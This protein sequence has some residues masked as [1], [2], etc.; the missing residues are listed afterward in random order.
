MRPSFLPVSI[1]VR[2]CRV[3][4]CRRIVFAPVCRSNVEF[5]YKNT[6]PSRSVHNNNMIRLVFIVCSLFKNRG[7]RVGTTLWRRRKIWN[8]L[9]FECVKNVYTPTEAFEIDENFISP[10]SGCEWVHIRCI[11]VVKFT[12]RQWYIKNKKG[13]TKCPCFG[14]SRG[15]FSAYTHVFSFSLYRSSFSFNLFL[16]LSS[17][18][19]IVDDESRTILCSRNLSNT[20]AIRA[21]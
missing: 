13:K 17:V 19:G 11:Y 2:I 15:K 10:I 6:S 4:V 9:R 20:F 3:C 1:H 8:P 16:R 18:T 5:E 14:D 21:L 12:L 7:L